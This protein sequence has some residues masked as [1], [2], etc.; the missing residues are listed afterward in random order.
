MKGIHATLERIDNSS[1]KQTLGF[2]N[3]YRDNDYIFGC[4]TMELAW[5]D[6]IRMISCIPTGKYIC[7]PYSSEKYP[8]VYE[9]TGVPNRDKI[10]IHWGNYH[11]N[12]L[13]CIG[14]GR[15][16]VDLDRDGLRDITDTR[17]V[18]KEMIEVLNNE[19]FEL[20]I[21]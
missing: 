10:L 21:L 20:T 1:N 8:Q 3:F 19:E 2:F 4:V 6:N 11:Y 16:F 15:E 7:K 18:I 17:N 14:A 13:G 9:V 5:K 12:Y